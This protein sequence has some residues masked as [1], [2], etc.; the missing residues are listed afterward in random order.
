MSFGPFKGFQIIIGQRQKLFCARNE[1]MVLLFSLE[2][3]RQGRTCGRKCLIICAEWFR[4]FFRTL[5]RRRHWNHDFKIAFAHVFTICLH[6]DDAAP[7]IAN[8][9]QR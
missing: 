4:Y 9:L 6:K 7:L 2:V 8:Y 1:E 3:V 5:R